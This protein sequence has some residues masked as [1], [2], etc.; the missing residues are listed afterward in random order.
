M[1]KKK[2]RRNIIKAIVHVHASFNNTIVT[3]TDVSGET[4]CWDSA[5]TVGFKGAVGSHL[6]ILQR[7]DGFK[8]FNQSGVSK[9]ISKTDPR[10]MVQN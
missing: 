8:G 1:S 3:F 6:E 7:S 4:L 2:V 5:G 9:I 10:K